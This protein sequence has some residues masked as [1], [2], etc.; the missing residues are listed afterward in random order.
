MRVLLIT[1]ELPLQRGKHGKSHSSARTPPPSTP[2]PHRSEVTANGMESAV[3]LLRCVLVSLV[4]ES[5]KAAA[6]FGVVTSW[7]WWRTNNSHTLAA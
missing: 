1:I 5:H 4:A 6:A 2:P 7:R 3:K